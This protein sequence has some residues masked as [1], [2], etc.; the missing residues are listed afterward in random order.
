MKSKF[1]LT[2][3]KS[4]S[5]F[6]ER[7]NIIKEIKFKHFRLFFK[8]LLKLAFFFLSCIHFFQIIFILYLVNLLLNI[9]DPSYIK[10]LVVSN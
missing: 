3:I 7:T 10:F 4:F 8:K 2:I 6:S 5:I 1:L 9:L